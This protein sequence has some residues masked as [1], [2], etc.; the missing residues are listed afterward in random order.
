[1]RRFTTSSAMVVVLV[2]GALFAP[3]TMAGPK[4]V[5]PAAT[6]MLQLGLRGVYFVPNQGQ[7]SDDGV[8]Y[9]LRS[10]GLDVA[11]RESALT[12]HMAREVESTSRADASTSRAREGLLP[13]LV[14]PAQAGI[15]FAQDAQEV[16]WMPAFAGMTDS[17]AFR[18][19]TREEAGSWGTSFVEESPLA[20]TRGSSGEP[21]TLE[22]LTLTI[23]FPGSNHVLPVGGNPQAAKFNYFVGGEG[24][25]TASDVP[26]QAP[27]RRWP[28]TSS[29]R[30][31]SIGRT[32]PSLM[33]RRDGR[34][35]DRPALRAQHRLIH[36]SQQHA[37]CRNAT[38]PPRQPDSTCLARRRRP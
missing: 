5:D 11:F 30:D 34:R 1:M 29:Q 10:R 16:R 4:E 27:H 6:E 2:C 28:A 9:G 19:Q 3:V 21:A 32:D 14:I 35:H 15:Q 36:H 23:T 24:R 8:M 22:R 37:V 20:D 18:R 7:W 25:S 13:K 17:K 26:C 12:M 38:R 33:V 31:L